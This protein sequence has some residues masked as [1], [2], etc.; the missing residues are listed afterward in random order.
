M[1]ILR[2]GVIGCG[3]I[4]PAYVKGLALFPEDV[5]LTAC[6]D[7]MEGR[8]QEFAAEYGL[9]AMSISELLDS[10]DVDLVLNLTIPAAHAEVALQ[11]ISAGKHI[12]NEKPLAVELTDGKKI[13][14]AAQ[15]AGVRAGCAPDT[16]LGGGIQ[17]ARALIDSGAIGQPIA[18]GAFMMGHGPES[19]HPNPFFFYEKGGGPVL[20]MAPYYLTALVNLMGPV[21]TVAAMT[22]AAFSE[23]VAGHESIR[24]QTMPVQVST[25]ATGALRFESGAM[26]TVTFSFDIW[27]HNMPRIEIYGTEGSMIVPDPNH[28]GGEIKVWDTTS[29]EWRVAEHTHR[30]DVLRGMG[31]VDMAR[32][33]RS[34]TEHRASAQLA[35]HVLEI[36]LAFDQSSDEQRQVAIQTQIAHPAALPVNIG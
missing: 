1:S 20:D 15:S 8:A 7:L 19:W 2:V 11:A 9:Q 23:R 14:E 30:V 13:L 33:I 31:V 32:A 26:A 6:A 12:Y 27:A 4:A 18:A 10:P 36:M 3:K 25:H 22:G 28:F 29:N 5:K 16:F 35:Q 21:Q 24:G 34:N 17:T